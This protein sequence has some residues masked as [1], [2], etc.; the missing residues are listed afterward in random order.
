MTTEQPDN[1]RF[2]KDIRQAA[3]D[4]AAMEEIFQRYRHE[5]YASSL[6]DDTKETWT[7]NAREF[8]QTKAWQQPEELE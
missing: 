1:V 3:P 5:V 4:E 7:A 8:I 6:A 2:R